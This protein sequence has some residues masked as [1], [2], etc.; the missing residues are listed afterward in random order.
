MYI[1]VSSSSSRMVY[2]C[3]YMKEECKPTKYACCPAVISALL[4]LSP[5]CSVK[6]TG[7][8]GLGCVGLLTMCDL[9]QLIADTTID[10]VRS[11]LPS[12]RSIA[13]SM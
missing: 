12:P 11:I 1:L 6:Y 7:L 2:L 4:R 3:M 9:W 13:F 10:L 5:P 8:L